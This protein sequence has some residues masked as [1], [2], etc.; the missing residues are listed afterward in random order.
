MKIFSS[1]NNMDV[2]RSAGIK[3][4][5]TFTLQSGQILTPVLVFGAIAVSFIATVAIWAGTNIKAGRLAVNRELAIQ[6]AEAGIDYYRWHLAHAPT[7]YQDGTG[8][9]GPYIHNFEDKDGNVVGTFTLEITAPPVGSTL[10]V[11]K[12]TGRVHADPNVKRTITTRLAKPSMA[13]FSV[14]GNA[15]MRFGEGT[16]VFGPIHINGGVR[17][18][19]F[20]HNVI[21]SSVSNY[22]DPDHGGLNEFGVHTHIAP[23]DPLPPAPVPPRPDVFEAGRQFPVPAVDFSGITADLAQIKANAQTD[24]FYRAGSGSLGYH[25]VFQINDTFDL[26]R[27][28]NMASLPN[29]CVNYANQPGWGAW[30]IGTEV[31]LGNY[32]IPANGLMFLEDNV[33]VDGRIQTA[34]V[35][36]VAAVLPDNPPTRKSI[37]IN[38]DLLY[39]N[40]DGQDVIG[41]IAQHNINVGMMSED[42]L[43]I[44]AALVAQY[45]RV[46][47]YYYAPPGGGSSSR[48]GPYHVR[49]II[50]LWGMIATNQ[51][52]GFAY[53]NG[54]GYETRNINYDANLLYG[55]PPSFPLTSD[56]YVTLSWEEVE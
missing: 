56:Q 6:I 10:V 4:G 2:M 43:R 46:G 25:I 18:D 42:D 19:G 24:G 52:Y 3:Q 8:T 34:R 37:T 36:V 21:S 35:T 14:L 50:T 23:V 17:F 55:P 41:L 45:G 1:H 26:Y 44:D 15:V 39:T 22:N 16:E 40:Y 27:I 47:R 20:A 5:K 28:T 53:T 49:E 29:G 48:C 7:D 33:W 11:I 13:K 32:P 12:S 31:P 51:R 30:S 54:T 9:P 38:N